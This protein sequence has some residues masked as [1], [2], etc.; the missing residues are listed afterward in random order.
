LAEH[1]RRDGQLTTAA[2]LY[3]RAAE[4][5]PRHFQTHYRAALLSAQVLQR[6]R[7][8]EHLRKALVLNPNF[9]PAH[10]QLGLVL[11]QQ[12]RRE[13]SRLAL[14]DAMRCDARL[15]S[16]YYHL[17]RITAQDGHLDAAEALFRKALAL[18]RRHPASYVRLGNLYVKQRRFAAALDVLQHAV[19]LNPRDPTGVSADLLHGFGRFKALGHIPR[20]EEAAVP[21]WARTCPLTPSGLPKNR[22][23]W[24]VPACTFAPQ[25]SGRPSS[26]RED[27]RLYPTIFIRWGVEPVYMMLLVKAAQK[28]L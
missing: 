16:A 2:E 1:A 13:D 5:Q 20:K 6:S 19:R 14:L 24:H 10:V 11:L 3:H 12:G 26:D 9:G 4:L 8:E 25:A 15:P 18:N 27:S 23:R 17:G 22:S 7:A 28:A 21:V